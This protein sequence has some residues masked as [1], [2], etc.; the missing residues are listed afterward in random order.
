M[1]PESVENSPGSFPKEGGTAGIVQ[2][3]YLTLPG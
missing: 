1:N 3:L 2:V